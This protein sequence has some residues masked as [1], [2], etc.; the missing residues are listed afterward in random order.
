V[1]DVSAK[2]L[3]DDRG[4]HRQGGDLSASLDVIL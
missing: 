3:H 4:P 1:F 2:P